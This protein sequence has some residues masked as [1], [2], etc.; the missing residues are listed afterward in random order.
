MNV[1]DAIWKKK[2]IVDTIK[3]KIASIIGWLTTCLFGILTLDIIIQG[4]QEFVST[5]IFC[6]FFLAIGIVFI[7]IGK[8]IKN[9]IN[10]CKRYVDI[11]GS[12]SKMSIDAIANI[13]SKSED[14]VLSDLQDM[15]TRQYFEQA[16]IDEDSWEFVLGECENEMDDEEDD[17]DIDEEDDDSNRIQVVTCS[18]CGAK[19]KIGKNFTGECEYC[20]SPI[21][22]K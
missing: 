1:N 20:G 3:C 12:K 5:F 9:R 6:I 4:S 13:M 15:I 18:S 17:D 19:N 7:I 16:Y 10:R 14:F 2:I 8:K 11:I 21:D 22:I